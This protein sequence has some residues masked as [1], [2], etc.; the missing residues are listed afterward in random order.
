MYKIVYNEM[1]EYIIIKICSKYDTATNTATFPIMHC[2]LFVVN[3]LNNAPNS[4]SRRVGGEVVFFP[5]PQQAMSTGLPHAFPPLASHASPVHTTARLIYVVTVDA[6][7]SVAV[8][9]SHKPPVQKSLGA[10]NAFEEGL[11]S[12]G[13]QGQ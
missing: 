1:Y 7:C 6:C 8:V 4:S 12:D 13:D 2:V 10:S 11:A 5:R 3:E 9:N